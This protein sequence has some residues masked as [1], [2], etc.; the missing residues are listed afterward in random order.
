MLWKIVVEDQVAVQGQNQD[1][2]PADN[3]KTRRRKFLWQK[4]VS[5][6]IA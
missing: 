5:L 4:S 6:L 3:F 2:G 1:H